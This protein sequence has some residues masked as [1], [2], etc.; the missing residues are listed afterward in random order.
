MLNEGIE[1]MHLFYL[2]SLTAIYLGHVVMALASQSAER[3][4]LVTGGNNFMLK[5]AI[6]LYNRR[7]LPSPRFFSRTT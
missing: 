4:V 5:H 2:L 3:T 1:G 7:M 6:F